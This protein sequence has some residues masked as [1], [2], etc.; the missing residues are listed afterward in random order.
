MILHGLLLLLLL[1]IVVA[2]LPFL[3][4][5]GGKLWLWLF[6]G[7]LVAVVAGIPCLVIL[8]Y[9][10]ALAGGFGHHAQRPSN[11]EIIEKAYHQSMNRLP[12]AAPE[13]APGTR[14]VMENTTHRT[15]HL[16]PNG[17]FVPDLGQ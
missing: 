9:V 12:E 6:Q 4:W 8:F 3:L 14:Y 15:G 5:L 11:G 13:W 7:A 1:P 17:V 16:L 2:M 10:I